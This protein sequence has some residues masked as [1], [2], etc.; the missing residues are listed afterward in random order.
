MATSTAIL[1]SMI[2]DI[3]DIAK[4]EDGVFKQNPIEFCTSEL[5]KEIDDL[6]DQ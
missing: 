2:D 1:S 6:F 5:I 4:L 3:L